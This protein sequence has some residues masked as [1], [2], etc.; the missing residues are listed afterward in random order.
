MRFFGH[1]HCLPTSR[2]LSQVLRPRTDLLHVVQKVGFGGG[3]WIMLDQSQTRPVWDRQIYIHGPQVN[4][5]LMYRPSQTGRVGVAC[6]PC[7][8]SVWCLA[9]DPMG[10]RVLLQSCRVAVA[11]KCLCRS[12]AFLKMTNITLQ[13]MFVCTLP[14]SY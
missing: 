5:P 8:L 14:C 13:K 3:I 10:C 7:L 1:D 12:N 2:R 4:H 9:K 6:P 11:R